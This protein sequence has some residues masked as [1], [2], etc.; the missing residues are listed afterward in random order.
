MS[1]QA[2]VLYTDGRPISV[3]EGAMIR[4]LAADGDELA[5]T[6]WASNNVILAHIHLPLSSSGAADVQPYVTSSASITLDGRI[7]NRHELR[8]HLGHEVADDISDVALTLAIYLRFGPEGLGRVVGDWSLAIWDAERQRLVL[9][10]D[11]A[12]VRPLYYH[13]DAKR[14]VWSTEL[15]S[16]IEWI[17]PTGIDDEYI[18]GVL[19]T[20]GYPDLTPY[21]GVFSVQ[22]ATTSFTPA[23]GQS[24]IHFG[25][26]RSAASFDTGTN[27][28]T[29]STSWNFSPTPCA[30]VCGAMLRSL[31]KSA[32]ALIHRRLRAW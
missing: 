12:G 6:S 19:T 22:P 15:K 25:S 7:D 4:K 29:K 31:Q 30:R 26:R 23:G 10:S 28:T 17:R 11:F 24:F 21:P 3:H 32:A 9:A 13:A 20:G 5:P 8:L 27:R 1:S 14:I 18:A 2:G 16:L